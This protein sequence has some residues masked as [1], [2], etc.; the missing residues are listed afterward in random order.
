MRAYDAMRDVYRY[1]TAHG[2]D[3]VLP[4]VDNLPLRASADEANAVKRA[5]SKKHFDYIR[6]DATYAVL[7]VNVDK[8]GEL[9]YIGPNAFAEIAVAFA[10]DRRIYLWQ[11]SPRRYSEEL[12]AW[13][14][15]EL[16]GKISALE[17]D[18]DHAT[19]RSWRHSLQRA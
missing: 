19:D 15:C 6:D 18:L 3:A 10:N 13:G 9:D 12:R 17:E 8:D 11:G 2:V 4:D 16:H 14:A 1:L 7:V 5:A